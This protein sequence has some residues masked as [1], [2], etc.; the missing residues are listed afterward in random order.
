MTEDELRKKGIEALVAKMPMADVAR[1]YERSETKGFMKIIVEAETKQL[2]GAALLGIEGDEI[3]Q[4]L[5]DMMYAKAPYTVIRRA[6]HIH[7]TVYEMI[8]YMFD[9]LRPLGHAG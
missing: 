3:V 7:P 5:L 1:A 2:L 9:G 6:M 4:G 8:P